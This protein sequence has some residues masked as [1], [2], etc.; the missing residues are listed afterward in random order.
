MIDLLS[1]TEVAGY[2]VIDLIGA[3]G[4][5]HVYRACNCG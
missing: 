5:G 1:G 4:M 2:R 3:G